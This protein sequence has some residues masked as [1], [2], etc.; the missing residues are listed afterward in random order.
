MHKSLLIA[1]G[2][3]L[4]QIASLARAE[5]PPEDPIGNYLVDHGS[6]SIAAHQLLGLADTVVSNLQSPRDVVVALGGSSNAKNGFAIAIMPGMFRWKRTAIAAD[7]YAAKDK[8]IRRHWA[9]TSF[10]YAKAVQEH[11]STQ[12]NAEGL[13]VQLGS[14]VDEED[15]PLKKRA[16]CLSGVAEGTDTPESVPPALRVER[17]QLIEMIPTLDDATKR[18]VDRCANLR[19]AKE[20]DKKPDWNASTYSVSLGYA[21]LRRPGGERISLGRHVVLTGSLSGKTFGADNGLLTATYRYVRGEVDLS[22]LGGVHVY[23]DSRLAA[24]RYKQ[25]FG[26]AER[27]FLLAEV[28]NV[29]GHRFTQANAAFKSAVGIDHR[30]APGVWLEFR[31]G[32]GR[33]VTGEGTENKS[34]LSLKLSP[35]SALGG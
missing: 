19:G 17:R 29:K 26:E 15:D 3:G 34:L 25:G 32:R 20:E 21:W 12:Y 13:A 33:A 7:D 6:T 35:T 1:V 2:V 28:S 30:L 18:E 16:K 27:T 23:R 4:T 9:R 5:E 8:F 31:Y 10:S 11:A 14:Y 24:L 22:T